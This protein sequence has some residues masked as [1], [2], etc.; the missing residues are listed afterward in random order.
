MKAR[1]KKQTLLNTGWETIKTL[2][3]AE[4]VE[5]DKKV[6]ETKGGKLAKDILDT[7]P[8]PKKQPTED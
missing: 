1:V 7:I 5:W 2:G 6:D 3:A 8:K 4:K